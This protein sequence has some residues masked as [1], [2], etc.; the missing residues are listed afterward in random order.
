M[1]FV[2]NADD[3]ARHRGTDPHRVVFGPGTHVAGVMML[4]WVS[5]FTSLPSRDRHGFPWRD[6]ACWSGEL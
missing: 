4:S 3:P 2:A 1:E 6:L 5:A